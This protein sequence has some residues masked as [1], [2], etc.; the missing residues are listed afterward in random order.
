[1]GNEEFKT[2]LYQNK[3]ID[4]INSDHNIDELFGISVFIDAVICF[5]IYADLNIII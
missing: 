5:R 3:C 1:M 4:L 2:P